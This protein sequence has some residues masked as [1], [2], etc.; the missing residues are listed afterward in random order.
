MGRA[1]PVPGSENLGAEGAKSAGDAIDSAKEVGKLFLFLPPFDLIG[2]QK[3]CAFF[4]KN[5]LQ[6]GS[7]ISCRAR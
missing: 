2:L 3:C 7:R 6:R 1:S 4:R 5:G